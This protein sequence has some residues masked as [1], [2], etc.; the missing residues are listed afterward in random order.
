MQRILGY[1]FMLLSL[2]PS[3]QAADIEA[4]VRA[5]CPHCAQA[6]SFLA[7][8]QREQPTLDIVIHDVGISPEAARRLQD[9]AQT[10]GIPPRVPTF[11]I[12]DQVLVGYS[13]AAGSDRLLRELLAR[14]A[15]AADH[16]AAHLRLF[17]FDLTPEQLGLPLFTLLMGLLDGFN[18]CSMWVLILMLTLLA[19]LNDRRRMLAIAGT[20]VVVQGIAYYLFMAAWLKLF[21]FI[22]LSRASEIVLA[23]LALFAGALNLKDAWHPGAGPSLSIPSA[24][25][26]GIYARMRRILRAQDLAAALVGTVLLGVLVQFVEL[27]CTSGFPALYTRILTQHALT[28]FGYHAY[29]LL[30]DLAY[31]LDD[32]LILAIG[33]YTLSQ[34]RLQEREGRAL[35]LLSALVMIGLGLYLLWP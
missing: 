3:A 13:A 29:L 8:L 21:L 14:D 33:V 35:K 1:L 17:G 31:M 19:P 25:K 32:F 12:G 20:F 16:R 24:A 26:P 27:L 34:R 9:I 18:P 11:L 22:G 28:G 23:L 5:G 10:Q 2:A 4:F 7:Q 15:Q 30:Y 6:E